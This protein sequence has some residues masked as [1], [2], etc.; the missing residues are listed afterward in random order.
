V[1]L[2]PLYGVETLDSE[3]IDRLPAF[4]RRMQ[5]F[6]EHRPELGDHVETCTKPDLR[7]LR[8]LALVGRER[9][10]GVLRYML[11]E[12]EFL[13]PYGVRALSRHHLRHPYELTVDGT[14]HRVDYEPGDSRCGLF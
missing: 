3:L 7:V 12:E 4:K 13:S 5:W 6:I 11:D 9:L 1:G 8:L 10:V 2:I 14:V